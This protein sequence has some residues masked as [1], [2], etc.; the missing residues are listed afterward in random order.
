M[1]KLLARQTKALTGASD[2]PL[3]ATLNE[4]ARLS[5]LQGISPA[6]AG[7][8]AGLGGFLS[9]VDEAYRQ[10]ERDL[11]VKTRSLQLSSIEL[12]HTN[13]RIRDELASRTRAIESLRETANALMQTMDAG[14]P[15]LE[16][17]NL[18]SL[19]RLMSELVQ[20]REE[21][22]RDLQSAL[23]DLANQ[24]FALDQHGIVSITN[25]AGE[26]IYANENFCET[27]G[28]KREKL[29]GADH[30]LL[31]SG[32]HPK[33]F[34]ADMWRVI[35][36]GEVWTGEICNRSRSGSLL[37]LHTTIVPLRDN[38]GM[39]TQFI[40]I[41]TD[42]TARKRME[43]A[44][45]GAEARVR[46][47]TNAV[48]GVVFQCEVSPQQT[49]F[50]FVNDRVRDIY[51]V[52]REYL[53]ADG[54]L[55]QRR[56]DPED[57]VQYTQGV[58]E[59]A[60]LRQPWSDDFRIRLPDGG[61]RWIRGEM[62]PE[63][64]L[65]ADGATVFT[66]IWQDVTQLK[67][68]GARL[69]EVTQNV[70]VAVFQF[71]PRVDGAR[72]FSFC[73]PAI[74]R[75]CGVTPEEVM[76]DAEQL[77]RLVHADEQRSVSE[78]MQAA[79]INGTGWSRDFRLLHPVTGATVWVRAEAQPR[80]GSDDGVLWNGYLA[81]ISESM[82]VSD[83]LR[84]AKEAAEAANRVKS[85]FLANMSHEIRT[86]MNG[87]I[88]MTE[89]ALE[90]EL[91]AEQREYLTMV[92]SSSE[93]LLKVINDILDFSK[94]EAGKLL[95][96]RIPFNLSRTVGDT[97][98]ALAVR[99]H[100]K[101][102]ELVCHI[103]R[104]VPSA[105]VGDPG[106]L[107]QILNNLIGNA[108]KFTDQGEIVVMLAAGEQTPAGQ[109]I[110]IRVRDTGI[111]IPADKLGS[112][113]DPFSQED[114]SITR[115]YGGTGLGLTIS[116]RLVKALG[117]DIS[118]HST[119]GKGSEFC[120]SVV[121]EPDTAAAS[122]VRKVTGLSGLRV[123]VVDDNAASRLALAEALEGAGVA[124]LQADGAEDALRMA[125]QESGMTGLFD[126]VMIDS[127]MPEADG[128]ETAQRLQALPHCADLPLVLLSP[129]GVKG[130][131]QRSQE[132]GF[133]AYVS[134]PFSPQE[135]SEALL[136][137]LDAGR[138]RGPQRS[139]PA[140]PVAPTVSLDIL[141]VEDQLVNQRLA[142]TLLQR[143]GHQVTLAEDG[144][145]ALTTLAGRRF[146]LVIMDV[147]MPVMDGLE[148]TR[149]FRAQE[150]GPRTPIVAMTANAMQGDRDACVAA[151]MDEYISK[152]ID[153]AELQA[154][155]K[156]HAR[157][158][159]GTHVLA[160]SEESGT[161]QPAEPA[162]D[163]DAALAAA[164]QEV[165]EIIAGTFLGQ[166]PQDLRRMQHALQ[167]GDLKPVLHIAHALKGTLAMFGAT[168]AVGLAQQIEALAFRQEA[169]PI[170]GLVEAL[171]QAVAHLNEALGR[172]GHVAAD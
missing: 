80:A 53:L 9:Q 74:E 141:L 5:R 111:G 148:A 6:A 7:V 40:A 63:P 4:L 67:E 139:I 17:D 20:Q 84:R 55:A 50:T 71:R 73:S 48:P 87:V 136:R 123:L 30:R 95:I 119:L 29:L 52:D 59:A 159:G 107:Q 77:F 150:Q 75:I 69:R 155:L 102:L 94:I 89:L 127:Q 108:I 133:K 90:T 167:A 49:R 145:Q 61:Q 14:L 151:G 54:A 32:V 162:F 36:A 100:T 115:R 153:T 15:P 41:R 13:D 164:D 27:S 93:S 81:D 103:D 124:V 66:G 104:A 98:K 12:M 19:T 25:V 132:A 121:L 130:D 85:D 120:F 31:N 125:R 44:L 37:W 172:A 128:F 166:W 135:I 110:D 91:D 134:K 118:V 18:E 158:L 33:A 163:H 45:K 34:F 65:A 42:V 43:V 156:R 113:F 105:V 38:R 129:A 68:A 149:R 99:A 122:A 28:Y 11:D 46:H 126:L 72:S 160:D 21:S 109:R 168:P 2:E 169:A 83:E 97:L 58:L 96:E 114:G 138:A 143:W 116:A 26:I 76:R 152:P 112:I 137:S 51:G 82:Q 92:K 117:G 146:D 86:P 144:Q 47:V 16:D 147:M 64:E 78:S 22:Q 170:A 1:H 24:K 60:R 101:G 106:R 131:I 39:P 35:T 79:A 161:L 140:T 165:V 10:N 57:Q 8:L 88:G 56:V 171:A 157:R 70:P 62:R 23:A 154:L 3:A 142:T